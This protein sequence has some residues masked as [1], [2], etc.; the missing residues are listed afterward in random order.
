M[1]RDPSKEVGMAG[2]YPPEFRQK[3]LD[4]VAS[5]RPVAE[6][7]VALGIS[8]QTIYNWRAQDLIDRG[9]RPWSANRTPS[10]R[11][12]RSRARRHLTGERPA[13]TGGA[14]KRPVPGNRPNG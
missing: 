7:A 9:E 10:H 1:P 8:N 4:L 6:I 11:G 2:R 5:C 13:E 14:P 3:V 12:A